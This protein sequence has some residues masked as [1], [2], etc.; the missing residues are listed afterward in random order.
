MKKTAI[1]LTAIL[2]FSQIAYAADDLQ[3]GVDAFNK[4]NYAQALKILQPLAEAG[5]AEAQFTLGAM[6]G[7]GTGV[8]R[9]RAKS[10]ELIT[11]SADQG[12]LDALERMVM[13]YAFKPGADDAE[14]DAIFARALKTYQ[15]EADKGNTKAMNKIAGMHAMG[16][17]FEQ[18]DAEALKWYKKA[19]ELGDATAQ[20]KV[21]YYFYSGIGGDKKESKAWFEKA[22]AQGKTEAKEYLDEIA[23]SEGLKNK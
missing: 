21:G 4:K 23:Y 20:F 17:S 9:D 14:V 13:A 7:Q 8:E 16:F 18:S 22:A 5:N 15:E 6:Y 3:M 11:K 1:I 2:G 19:A 12:N 10:L